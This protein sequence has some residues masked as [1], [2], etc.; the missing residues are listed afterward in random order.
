[1]IAQ[2]F[3]KNA[4]RLMERFRKPCGIFLAVCGSRSAQCAPPREHNGG[5]I[6]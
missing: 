2:A 3:Q 5:E 1:M 6:Y 4:A